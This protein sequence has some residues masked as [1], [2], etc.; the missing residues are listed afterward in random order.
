MCPEVQ[1]FR[2]V[3][4]RKPHAFP[5]AFSI[6][7]A[8]AVANRADNVAYRLRGG[9][10]AGFAFKSEMRY[11]TAHVEPRASNPTLEAG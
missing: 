11:K 4:H 1:I 6:A 8:S 10:K 3:V 5:Q 7:D 9:V 2:V